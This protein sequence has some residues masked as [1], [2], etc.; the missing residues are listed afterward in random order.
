MSDPASLSSR[1]SENFLPLTAYAMNPVSRTAVPAASYALSAR[2]P[3]LFTN[4]DQRRTMPN[5]EMSSSIC[6]VDTPA[7][8]TLTKHLT[9][10]SPVMA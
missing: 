5:V 7:T 8:G 6:V 1:T 9:E 3:E 4:T 10:V 2:L